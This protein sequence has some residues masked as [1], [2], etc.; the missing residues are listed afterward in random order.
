MK[1]LGLRSSTT[2]YR[3]SAQTVSGAKKTWADYVKT[4]A[5]TYP[6]LPS[7]FYG[8]WRGSNPDPARLKCPDIAEYLP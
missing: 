5:R 1:D 3:D 4:F 2:I 6:E 8:K 7:D